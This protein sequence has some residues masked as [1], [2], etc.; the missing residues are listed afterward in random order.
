[1]QQIIL[2]KAEFE[3]AL[4][5][6][7]DLYAQDPDT[8]VDGI[9]MSLV[10][11]VLACHD[12]IINK[13]FEIEDYVGV[14]KSLASVVAT[15]GDVA[16]ELN[17]KWSASFIQRSDTLIAQAREFADADKGREAHLAANQAEQMS[18][19]RDVVM[20]LQKELLFQFPMIVIGVSQGAADADPGRRAHWGSRRAGL[21]TQ[22]TLFENTGLTDEGGKFEFLNGKF[23]PSDDIGRKYTIE[24]NETPAGFAVPHLDAY[25]VS[26]RLL[27]FATKGS[28]NYK[29]AWAKVLERVEIEGKNRVTFTLRTAF[30]RPEALLKLTFAD[31]DE[32]GVPDQNGFY[33]L[34]AEEKNLMTYEI[35]PRYPRVA[36]R[37]NP[38]LVEQV[39]R[40]ASE[41]VDQL[42]AGNVTV[43]DRVSIA[44]MK[45]LRAT[46][47]IKV[48]AY[49]LPTVH[50]LVPKIRG[51]LAKDPNFRNGLS[52]AIDRSMLVDNGYLWGQTHQRL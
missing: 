14:R 41:A 47:E 21:L 35:N 38:V 26:A 17:K 18:P 45:R 6:F 4:S 50:M 12:G 33:V 15:Y 29:P 20:K 52:H 39:F 25:Q 13:R 2:C 46:P 5:I 51:E 30:V 37:Q 43:V 28:R 42:I 8:R 1:M 32:N 49:I 7:E 19:G 40:D 34:T 44:D 9:N 27:S 3:L 48:R 31:P 23:F 10:K 11:I 36:Q 24:I 22:R 16:L